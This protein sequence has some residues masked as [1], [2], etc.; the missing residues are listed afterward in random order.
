MGNE[1]DN[2][3]ITRRK[4]KSTGS[5]EGDLMSW[6]PLHELTYK[7]Q[8]TNAKCSRPLFNEKHD[9]FQECPDCG[10]KNLAFTQVRTGKNNVEKV[11][12]SGFLDYVV[13]TCT[14]AAG[15]TDA[16]V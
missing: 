3:Q 11:V 2:V 6:P 16:S 10:S 1:G 5:E 14:G 7:L 15:S 13:S 9:P 4:S 8:C 12:Q